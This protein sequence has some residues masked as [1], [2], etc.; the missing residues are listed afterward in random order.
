[1]IVAHDIQNHCLPG[2]RGDWEPNCVI[3]VVDILIVVSKAWQNRMIE[4]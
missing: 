4:V 1:M 2:R 3:V